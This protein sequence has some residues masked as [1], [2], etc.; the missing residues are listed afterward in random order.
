MRGAHK[1]GALCV[2]LVV[3]VAPACQAP[4][5]RSPQGAESAP[6]YVAPRHAPGPMEGVRATR[7]ADVL[8][9]AGLDVKN[10]PPIERLT[11]GQKQKVMRT[12]TETLG[13]PCLGCHAEDRFEA[14]TRRKRIAKRMY[15]E[16]V[17]PLALRDGEPIYCDSCHDGDMFML[18]R[19]DTAKVT[20]HMSETL[21]GQMTRV[22]GRPHDCTS[23]HGDPPD[24]KMLTTWKLTTA[25][26]I[27]LEEEPEASML[28][29]PPLPAI[30]PRTPA[31]CGPRSELCPLQALM[32]ADISNAVVAKDG[33]SL[34][35]AMDRVAAASP[36][37]S[38]AWTSIGRAGAA[39]AR[40]GD[41]AAV[42]Q[43]CAQCHELYKAP[44]RESHRTRVVP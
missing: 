20:R 21:V 10:L 1:W 26:D 11:P 7:M 34:A 42:R 28:T 18:D 13:V 29:A 17:R 9:A 23:C 33:A 31:D 4:E 5:A 8:A 6:A 39:A 19:R 24:F 32:R 44:W 22:D 14:D 25:P 37:P 43:A 40:A 27:V 3:L 30:G 41:R 15:N 12:F 36:D 38:W 35:A 2:V 16:I